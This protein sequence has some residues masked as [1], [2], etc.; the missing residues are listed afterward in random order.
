VE[1]AESV[2]FV[3]SEFESNR[4]GEVVES[5]G[6]IF[7][8]SGDFVACEHARGGDL[9]EKARHEIAILTIGV[10]YPDREDEGFA[11]PRKPRFAEI[12]NLPGRVEILHRYGDGH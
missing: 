7:G 8:A 4:A 10:E 1:T 9:A 5:G 12:G 2:Y 6:R 3:G 11:R